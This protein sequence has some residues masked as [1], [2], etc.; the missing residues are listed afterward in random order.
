MFMAKV[1]V[2]EAAKRL[3]VGVPRVHQRIRDGSLRAER[4]GSQ[5]VVDELSLIRAAESRSGRP[6]SARSAWAIIAF[7][8]GD[9]V[10]LALL[11]AA[12]RSRAKVRLEELLALVAKPPRSERAVRLVASG[13]RLRFRNRARMRSYKAA[14]ADLPALRNDPRWESVIGAAASGIASSDVVGYLA[15]HNVDA[16]VREYLLV[17][18]DAEANVLMHVLP[19]GQNPY[20]DSLL[21][22]AI[23]L[24]DLR[25]PR[26]ELRAA[27]LLREVAVRQ[28]ALRP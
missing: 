27:E 22:L 11:A 24:A 23:D 10:A 4:L 9:D 7:A 15:G 6:L 28:K 16:V 17:P 12:E 8:E 13:L 26:E 25:G 3:N 14:V 21:R 5:W 19:E 18:A 1:S 2:A 20:P